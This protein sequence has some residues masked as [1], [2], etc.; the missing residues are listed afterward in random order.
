[1]WPGTEQPIAS[2]T[3]ALQGIQILRAIAA[4][5]VVLHHSLEESMAA[6]VPLTIPDCFITFGAAGVDIFFV[7]SGFIM[8]YVSFPNDKAAASPISFLVKRIMR[9]Y[10]LY[11][12][13]VATLLGLWSIGLF[14]SLQLDAD[15]LVRSIF[16]F[17]S[18]HLVIN[19]SWTLVYEMYFYLIFAATLVYSRPI[20]SLFG[21]SGAILILYVIGHFAP[22]GAAR[23]FLTNEIAVEFC[24]GL[25]LGYFFQRFPRL[26]LGARLL[27]IPGF[28]LILMAPL[29]VA[30]ENTNG[31]PGA[32]RLLAWGIP[33]FLIVLS[34]LCL[35]A[36]RTPL[37]RGMALLGD[38]SYAIYLTHPFVMITYAKLLKGGLANLSQWPMI[39]FF[40]L[41]S[42][43]LGLFVH[44]F[45]ER[46]LTNGFRNL[47]HMPE[48]RAGHAAPPP[49]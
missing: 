24:F 1:M 36:S 23:I 34:F 28:A 16:L 27:S 31:L 8:F 37:Q 46:R 6:V 4:L 13:C 21:T 15:V 5:I 41:L 38:A 48:T 7:I 43:G 11:W 35:K 42:V 44:I 12:F 25:F 3:P 22:D 17:P 49:A 30:H 32:A 19:V 20:I 18:E 26:F 39:P 45:I 10:P 29:V 9:I 40:V 33:A 2:R 47:L 14:H